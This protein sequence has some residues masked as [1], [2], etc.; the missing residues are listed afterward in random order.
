[1]L[2]REALE[3]D[4]RAVRANSRLAATSSRRRAE[5]RITPPEAWLAMRAARTTWVP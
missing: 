3:R 4:G 2:A 1:V 5:T